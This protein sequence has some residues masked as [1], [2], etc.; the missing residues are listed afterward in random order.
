LSSPAP[1]AASAATATAAEPAT[2]ARGDPVSTSTTTEGSPP[3]ARRAVATHLRAVPT[4]GA[5]SIAGLLGPRRVSGIA[6]GILSG[7]GA[8]AGF[9][10]GGLFRP[11]GGSGLGFAGAD[12][13]GFALACALRRL[14]LGRPLGGLR[15]GGSLGGLG[16]ARAIA[17]FALG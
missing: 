5:W 14:G 15:L 2:P 7:L 9:V 10:A 11:P 17:D 13:G 16:L 6:S 12:L 8:R 1:S 3:T 4:A